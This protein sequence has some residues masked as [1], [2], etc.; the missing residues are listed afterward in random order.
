MTTRTPTYAQ[1]LADWSL[2]LRYEDIPAEMIADAKWRVLDTIGNMIAGS[3]EPLAHA[4]QRAATAFGAGADAKIIPSGVNVPASTAALV[5]GTF[6]HAQDFDDTHT[7]TLVHPSA[8]VLATAF[9][10]AKTHVLDGRDLLVAMVM[11]NEVFCRLGMVAP[12]AFHRSGIH[13]TAVLGPSATAL[14]AARVMGLDAPR[15]VNAMGI[16]GSQASGILESFA[17]G[18]WVKTFHAGWAAHSGVMAATLAAHGFTGPTTVLEGRFGLFNSHIQR[19]DE[20]LDLGVVTRGLGQDWEIRHLCLKPYAC[21]HVIHPYVDLA[22]NL[23]ARGVNS[24][25]I[26]EITVPI[27]PGYMPV[28]CE[29]RNAKIAPQTPT[30]AR[31]SLPYCVAAALVRGNL[32]PDAFAPDALCVPDVLSL[33]ARITAERDMSPDLPGQFRGALQVKLRDGTRID[34]DQHHHRG[35]AA[36]P[37]AQVEIAAKFRAN[38]EPHLGHE[39]IQPIIEACD[40]LALGGEVT[41]LINLCLLANPTGSA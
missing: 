26:A 33:A 34:L 4:V 27:K 35:S 16:S 6:G 5:N 23:H 15:A 10:L 25:Q 38:V 1:E 20:K 14:V 24:D 39:K 17:D 30:H 22:L 11:G 8:P 37:L 28:V 18:S 9:A 2:R 3:A 29:P 32:A 41:D 19:D 21:A 13:P 12:M 36:H 40:R 7:A 31:A